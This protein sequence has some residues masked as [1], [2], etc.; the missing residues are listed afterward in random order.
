MW[1]S[2]NNKGECCVIQD[3]TLRQVKTFFDISANTEQTW[4]QFEPD[5]PEKFKKYANLI[6]LSDK[7][8]V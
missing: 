1:L 7:D 2:N 6:R 8:L 3:E 4:I 5:T